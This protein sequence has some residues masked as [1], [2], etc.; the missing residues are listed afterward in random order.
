[1]KKKKIMEIK[2]EKD[3]K[4]PDKEEIRKSCEDLW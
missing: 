2:E 1:M 3:Y 4:Y